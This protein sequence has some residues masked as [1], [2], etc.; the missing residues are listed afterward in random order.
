MWRTS[1]GD[2][3]FSDVEWNLFRVGLGDLL[4]SIEDDR[5]EDRGLSQTGIRVFDSLQPDQKL[6]IRASRAGPLVL[7]LRFGLAAVGS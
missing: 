3:V 2:R 7:A 5:I 1:S 6:A 4:D